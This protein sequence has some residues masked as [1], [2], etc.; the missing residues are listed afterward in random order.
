MSQ[1]HYVNRVDQSIPEPRKVSPVQ[2]A[3]PPK[4]LNVPVSLYEREVIDPIV[5]QAAKDLNWPTGSVASADGDTEP[6]QDRLPVYDITKHDPRCASIVNHEGPCQ[7]SD[8]PE[9]NFGNTA[10]DPDL[11]STS[12]TPTASLLNTMIVRPQEFERFKA[13]VIMAFK[14]QGIDTRKF[15]P[16]V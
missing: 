11:A 14:H 5:E 16:E 13:Q 1:T 12:I 7:V 8:L 3:E 4:P 2:T 10:T 9:D 6:T 15:F